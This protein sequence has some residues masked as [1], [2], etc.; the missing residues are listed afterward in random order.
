MSKKLIALILVLPMVL[1]MTLFST[2]K[3]VSLKVR[4]PVSK[5]EILG[6]GFVSLDL[7]K[8]ETYF[9]DYVIYPT[10]AANKQVSFSYEQVGSQ[11]L[12]ELEYK[13]G[14]IY[15]KS[16]GMAYAYISTNDGGHRARFQVVVNSTELK[17][18]SCSVEKT[19]LIVGEKQQIIT[20]FVPSSATDKTLNYASSNNNVISVDD[21]GLVVA[22][23]KGVASI[24]ISSTENSSI[25]DTI[26][27]VVNTD[28]ILSLGDNEIT[29]WNQTG[30]ISLTI[31]TL[32][33]YSLEYEVLDEYGNQLTD[34]IEPIDQQ[35][36]FTDIGDGNFIFNYKFVDATFYGKAV[37]NFTII[38]NSKTESKFCDINRIE[39]LTAEFKEQGDLYVQVGSKVG[40]KNYITILPSDAQV[41]YSVQYSNGNIT[42]GEKA[43]KMGYT[44]ATITITSQENSNQTIVLE[45]DVYIY[46]D[47][48]HIE[49]SKE[50]GREDVLTI[51][52]TDAWGRKISHQL[53]LSYGKKEKGED[54]DKLEQ[55]ISFE[56][57]EPNKVKVENSKIEI[58]DQTF[59]GIVE[60]S[61]KLDLKTQITSEKFKVRCVGYG[62]EVDNFLDLVKA[63]KENK[64]VILQDDIVDDFGKDENGKNYYQGANIQ[65][66]DSTYDTRFYGNTTPQV[67]TLLQFKNDLY[68]NGHVINANNITNVSD[69]DRFNNN[70]LFNGPLNFVAMGNMASVKGQDNICYAV[71]EGVKINNVELKGCTLQGKNG[72]QDLTD[73]DYVGTV[74]E[75][76]GDNV[77]IEYSGINNGRTVIRAFGDVLD[78]EKVINVSI[79][80]SVLSCARE[81]IVRI[82]SNLLVDDVRDIPAT[83]F[84]NEH[85][86][87]QAP[88]IDPSEQFDFPVQQEYVPN[89]YNDYEQKY[90]KTKLSIENSV[91]QDSGIFSI[92]ID[93]HF[94]GAM[95]YDALKAFPILKN[96]GFKD[97]LSGWKGLSSTSY[98]AKLTFNGDVRIY[99]WKNVNNVDS[100]TLIEMGM[101]ASDTLIETLKFDVKEMIEKLDNT[102]MVYKNGNEQYVHGGIV[103]FGGGKN[104]GVFEDN[105]K[106]FTG[107]IADGEE[108]L[109]LNEYSISLREVGQD[110]LEK[111]AGDKPFYFVVYRAN[112]KFTPPVQQEILGGNNAYNCIYFK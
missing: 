91:L 49:Q 23:G 112:S 99:D 86:K 60:I 93:S 101:D 77:S 8:G 59:N 61:A 28:K 16:A 35:N 88:D 43:S 110:L 85:Y 48:L 42:I 92:G 82:G 22:K 54:F 73:L 31:D 46:P 18:I 56:T 69:S 94:S 39:N 78:K 104:Y 33:E 30:A 37:I 51:G 45:K 108:K 40:W 74:V 57:S 71:F 63:T 3:T 4:V 6:D 72:E 55:K 81:F 13:N 41:N 106:S 53:S 103:F 100:S 5:I 21:N 65:K 34:V 26:D 58:L 24:T 83:D 70:A 19:V 27:F 102:S 64:A 68:G 109:K 111:A 1:M 7:D 9:V 11:P 29:T 105:S 66:I 47:G 32:E 79:K 98:G 50:Y 12:A 17:E 36:P 25:V 52:K 76:L 96:S 87:Y 38:T 15:P 20:E 90:I 107:L 75:V 10:T 44:K 14:Y 67:I 62:V 84:E 95:L 2:V 89:L 80:N 97:A